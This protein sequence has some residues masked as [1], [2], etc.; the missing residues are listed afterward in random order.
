MLNRKPGRRGGDTALTCAL[1][2]LHPIIKT[3]L[4]HLNEASTKPLKLAILETL[5]NTVL[6]NPSAALHLM[7]STQ[8][9][10]SRVFFEKWFS[11]LKSDKGLPRVHD[12]KLS[13]LAMCALLEMDAA[14]IPAP[15]RDGWSGIVAAI[16][17]VF[18]DLPKAVEGNGIFYYPLFSLFPPPLF[19]VCVCI[20]ILFCSTKGA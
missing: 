3:S 17:H 1:K 14:A 16:L 15:L 8:A 2:A 4:E 13:I 18:K 20:L 7:E 9:G 5:I 6:Y 11:I 12:K 19:C 10:S